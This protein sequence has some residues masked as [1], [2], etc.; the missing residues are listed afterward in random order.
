MDIVEGSDKYERCP[1]N[2]LV[3]EFCLKE[4]LIQS[5]DCPICRDLYSP[6]IIKKYRVYIKQKER[7]KLEEFEKEMQAEAI[8]SFESAASKMVF[9]K[10]IES[11]EDLM[12]KGLFDSALERLENY[13]DLDLSKHTGQQLLFLKG[14]INYLRGRYD[15]AINHLFKLVKEKF[16]FP[17]AFFYLGKSYEE[18]GLHDKAKWAFDRVK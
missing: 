14:K 13:G 15:L 9:L 10:F 18:L 2:H 3:H 16:D 8:K 17:N 7:E 11:I 1:N 12:K 5:S 6:N 4:W